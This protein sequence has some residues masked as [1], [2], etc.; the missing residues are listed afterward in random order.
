MVRSAFFN[1]VGLNVVT[2]DNLGAS[3]RFHFF[4]IELG[5]AQPDFPVID[6]D[7]APSRGN[8]VF[9]N[10]VRGAH[11]AG[12]F[13]GEGSTDNELFDNTVFGAQTWALEQVRA[14]R[15]QSLNNLTNLPS[16]NIG[17]GLDP[18]LQ[19][20]GRARFDAAQQR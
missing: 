6:L 7:F 8:I 20:L 12:I 17:A 11:Y 15:N 10:V 5:A 16:R 3:D 19:E 9:G 13:L 4:G 2:D 18:Q 1:I 14:Q